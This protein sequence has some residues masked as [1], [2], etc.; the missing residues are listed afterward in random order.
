MFD[1]DDAS[2]TTFVGRYI[3]EA[4]DR[5]VPAEVIDRTKIHVLDGLIAIVSGSSLR[6]GQFAR[7][8]VEKRATRG[9][10]TV[11]GTG[12]RTSPEMAALA[13]GMFAHADETDDTNDLSR[14]H[15]GA[16]IIPGTLAVAEDRDR[17]GAHFL[18]A[19]VAGYDVGC[20]FP[21]AVW[22]PGRTLRQSVQSTHGIGQLFGAMAGAAALAELS[23]E[24]M[25][26]VLSYTAQQASGFSALFRDTEHTE[27]A[28][29]LGGK[30]AHNAVTAVEMVSM[31]FTGVPDILHRSPSLFDA[32]GTRGDPEDLRS[33]L[34][35]HFEVLNCD[36][37]RYPVGMPIQAAAQALEEMLAE[38]KTETRDVVKVVCRLPSEKAHI[39]DARPMPDINVQYILTIMLEDGRIGFNAAH[40][41]A[42][43]NDPDVQRRMELVQLIHDPA[44]DSKSASDTTRRAEIELTLPDGRLLEHRVD[45]PFGTRLNPIDWPGMALKA[46]DVL[47]ELLPAEQIDALISSVQRLEDLP[48]IRD[49]R[50]L[51]LTNEA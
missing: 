2:L 9:E 43:L 38:H 45:P 17:S 3:A 19:V 40:D 47:G 37:K 34:N 46:H 6:P 5:D 14:M 15:P 11:A 4:L 12:L 39:V 10:S 28:F 33:R 8:F 44:L 29:V 21:L 18:K 31:G 30:Q 42:R 49:L 20:A 23:I 51:I 50:P 25:C 35:N 26:H 32:W 24:Q 16:S 1:P 48:S 41:Y 27:K 7:R 36:I 22:E 13:N